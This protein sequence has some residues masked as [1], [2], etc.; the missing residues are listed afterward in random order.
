M[1][2]LTLMLIFDPTGKCTRAN[3]CPYKHDPERLAICPL[4]LRNR[5]PHDG[6]PCT[7][8]HTP[9]S[10][11]TPSCVRFQATSTCHYSTCL[12]PHIRVSPTAP[13]C[14]AF[15]RERWCPAPAGTCP[16]LHVWECQEWREHGRC[17]RGKACGLQHVLRADSGAGKAA[18]KKDGLEGEQVMGAVEVDLRG[19]LPEESGKGVG[20]D[21]GANWIGLAGSAGEWDME[22]GAPGEVSEEG[23]GSSEVAEDEDEDDDE[24]GDDEDEGD[25]AALITG[26]GGE[27]AVSEAS[28]DGKHSPL[29]FFPIAS[30]AAPTASCQIRSGTAWTSLTI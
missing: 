7:L 12:Y 22:Q 4:F 23:E 11:N 25:E 21:D 27:E 14:E 3:V 1:M 6:V 30:L 29:H 13:V 5:G 18:A 19:D 2:L 10:H 17:S 24:D 15:A 28:S 8:S 26:T 9:S 16:N 20:F